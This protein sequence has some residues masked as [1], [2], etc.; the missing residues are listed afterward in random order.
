YVIF[1]LGATTGN[2]GNFGF[3]YAS[4]NSANN[5]F[6][7]GTYGNNSGLNIYGVAAGNLAKVKIGNVSP[8]ANAPTYTVESTGTHQIDG[9]IIS[10]GTKFTTSGCSVSATTGGAI[11]GTYTSGTTGTCTV[12]VTM[13]GATG[14]TAPN[15]WSCWAADLTTP[16]D[17]ITQTASSTTT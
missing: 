13:N 6:N 5:N 3:Y 2:S 17:I 12:V 11:A 8:S 9:G 14:V 7:I 16:A 10:G 1:G 15:G 4:L